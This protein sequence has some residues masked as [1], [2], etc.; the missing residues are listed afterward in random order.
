MVYVVDIILTRDYIQEQEWPKG[1]LTKEFETKDLGQLQYFL[2]MEIERT[3]K[4]ILY[5]KKKKTKRKEKLG[6]RPSKRNK[7][8]RV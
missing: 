5:P 1:A 2:G 3:K 7:Y 8:A 6:Y 4:E